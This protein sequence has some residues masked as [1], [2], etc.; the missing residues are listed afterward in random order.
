MKHLTKV[1]ELRREIE[2]AGQPLN[3][4]RS[5]LKAIDNGDYLRIDMDFE[6]LNDL[7]NLL[8]IAGDICDLAKRKLESAEH[9]VAEL[10]K[11]V[12]RSP[13]PEDRIP[14]EALARMFEVLAAGG[15]GSTAYGLS[16]LGST[17]GAYAQHDH[18][19]KPAL[20]AWMKWMSSLEIETMIDKSTSEFRLG[21]Q[22]APGGADAV[23][24][25][26]G[27]EEE[28]RARSS[29]DARSFGRFAA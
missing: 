22:R 13:K 28:V 11:R 19:L 9:M 17:L 25:P 29:R 20:E 23:I 10:E 6:R 16:V 26:L 21:I 18:A 8:G 12:E 4:I 3:Q 2:N 1:S 7:A 27:L 5:I 24:A 14:G 15:K